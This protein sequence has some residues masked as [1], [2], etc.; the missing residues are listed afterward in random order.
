MRTTSSNYY[1][2]NMAVSD[3]VGVILNWPLYVTESMLKSGG[4]LISQPFLASLSCKL[5]IYSRSLSYVVSILSL[6]LM[7]VD[8]FIATAFPL[9]TV[10]ASGRIR[11]TLLFLMWFLPALGLA[12]FIVHV[13]IIEVKRQSFC[14][15]MM[16]KSSLKIY[17]FFAFVLFYCAP[18]ILI[19]V[20]YPL[21]MKTLQRTRAQFQNSNRITRG[22]AKRHKQEKNIMKIFGSIVFGF[23]VCWT[24]YYVYLFLK[25]FYPAI[26]IKDKCLLLAGLFYYIFPLLNTVI[27]PFI[28]ITFSS[29][30]RAGV[31]RLCSSLLQSYCTTRCF[32]AAARTNVRHHWNEVDF[33]NKEIVILYTHTQVNLTQLNSRT[34][35][36]KKNIVN[37]GKISIS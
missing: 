29:S 34:F 32:L 9:Y 28:L 4:S 27:N 13:K 25:S 21:I 23:F 24:P 17:Y 8:R 26:F 37:S 3:L 12:P 11:K 15:N 31:K 2:V 22:K 14:R 30:Y 5:G 33:F 16:S 20:L 6:V 10:H 19:L 35:Q 1:I 7:A 36:H 18:L